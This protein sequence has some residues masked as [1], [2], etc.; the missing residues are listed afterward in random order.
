[1]SLGGESK[2]N[3]KKMWKIL[4]KWLHVHFNV[5]LHPSLLWKPGILGGVQKSRGAVF[6]I[7]LSK[8]LLIINFEFK[9]EFL[10]ERTAWKAYGCPAA[11]KDGSKSAGKAKGHDRIKKQ[12]VIDSLLHYLVRKLTES[13]LQNLLDFN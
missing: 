13:V 1:M 12:R 7:F 11:E 10:T 4:W 8:V 2:F 9:V 5:V 6:P 3:K